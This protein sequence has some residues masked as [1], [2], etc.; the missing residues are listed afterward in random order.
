MQN[1]YGYP[2]LKSVRKSVMPFNSPGVTLLSDN[3][4]RQDRGDSLG[5]NSEVHPRQRGVLNICAAE[6][7]CANS[8][9]D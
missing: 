8:G 5:D 3:K 9:H 2:N 6:N 1:Q 7:P 4:N